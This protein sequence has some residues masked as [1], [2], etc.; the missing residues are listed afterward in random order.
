MKILSFYDNSGPKLHRVLT[1]S[2][3]LQK[4]GAE[5]KVVYRIDKE[6]D[7]EGT[8]ILFFNRVIP[9]Q[10]HE[11]LLMWREKYGFKLVCD[12]DDHWILDKGHPLYEG[13][14]VH[15]V[16]EK[17]IWFIKNSDVVTVTHERLRDEVLPLNKNCHI[18]PNSIPKVL[19]FTVKKIPDE[20]VRLFWAGGVT[21]KRD[22]ELLR[23]PLK[24][25]KRQ[26]VK[27]VIGGYV[28]NEPEWKEMAKIFTTDSGYNTMV[29]E[30]LP[31]SEYYNTYGLCDIS[32]I[33]LLENK[34][35]IYKSN[36]KIL[37]AGN[38]GAPV[39]VSSVH[40]YLD[41][42]PDIVNYVDLHNTWYGQITK[43]I[44]DKGFRE[45]QGQQ[46]KEYCDIHYNFDKISIERK[47]IFDAAIKSEQTRTISSQVK[48]VA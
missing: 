9:S 38:I 43:L 25:I 16:S 28:K 39:V 2:Y 36:L 15:K 19:Q 30:S 3:G 44:R 47:Q 26:G 40:P 20:C 35:N 1:P 42:P 6:S 13:Y 41:F 5:C 29:I 46:L 48:G 12:L 14:G 32:L 22:L 23:E 8:D 18:L 24:K 4:H 7:L 33:P 11:R 31:P 10:D 21:H 17:I 37:E 27:F 45:E 34:F